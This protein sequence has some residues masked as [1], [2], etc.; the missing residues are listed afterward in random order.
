MR[1]QDAKDLLFA[2][3]ISLHRLSLRLENTPR[4][5]ATPDCRGSSEHKADSCQR[6]VRRLYRR[7]M[8]LCAGK[9]SVEHITTPAMLA[10]RVGQIPILEYTD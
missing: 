3:P 5:Q 1:F 7:Y 6:F 10:I 4:R 8:Y 9:L 2:E